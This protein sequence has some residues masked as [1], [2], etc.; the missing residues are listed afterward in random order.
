[1]EEPTMRKGLWMAG[2]LMV[3]ATMVAGQDEKITLKARY[4]PGTYVMTMKMDIGGTT[5]MPEG[6][7]MAHKIKMTIALE[8]EVGEKD[9]NGLQTFRTMYK[10]VAQSVETNGMV[11]AYD[12]AEPQ[13]GN[14]M[15]AK[16]YTPMLEHPLVIKMD[17][18]NK[19]V[20][21][22]GMDEMWD[23]MIAENPQ[24]AQMAK[25]MKEQFGNDS[26]AQMV[27]WAGKMMPSGP[28]AVGN[29]WETN[30]E[31]PLPGLGQVELKRKCTLKEIKSI[32]MGK[33]AVIAYT[34]H[35]EKDEA[36]GPDTGAAME[37]TFNNIKLSQ[38]GTME[39]LVDS[40]MPLSY[41][42]DRKMSM[43]MSMKSNKTSGGTTQPAG[44]SMT[45]QQSGK[46]EMTVRKGK[47]VPPA[48]VPAS[49]PAA[50][51][52]ITGKPAAPGN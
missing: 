34:F 41:Q 18:N 29:S 21:V 4:D 49:Q 20:S 43:D 6:Q 35:A 13:A 15:L 46:I 42:G 23:A 33:V 3:L 40:G 22:S 8:M 9:A 19:V 45:T 25:G 50:S 10:R 12:S 51:Q 14:P 11:M 2:C 38:T 5:T 30:Q 27:D 37:M 31:E 48:T 36:K 7:S 39:M 32:P 16:V 17:A 24:M 1:M 47:Y 26:I 52:P 44:M 28:V